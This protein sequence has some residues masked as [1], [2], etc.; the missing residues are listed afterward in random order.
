MNGLARSPQGLAP[1]SPGHAEMRPPVT[2]QERNVPEPDR[3]EKL[4]LSYCG[5]NL[6]LFDCYV[7]GQ[8]TKK[9]SPFSIY[10]F[11]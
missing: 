2:R 10:P 9:G 8:H 1:T 3:A 4:K 5:Q 11:L 6:H 7:Q